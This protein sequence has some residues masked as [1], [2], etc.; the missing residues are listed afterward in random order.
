MYQPVALTTMT[1]TPIPPNTSLLL[2]AVVPTFLLGFGGIAWWLMDGGV[3]GGV[4]GILGLLGCV[5]CV[6]LL[7]LA[8][9]RFVR[10]LILHGR[11]KDG[12]DVALVD[13]VLA[14]E[15]VPS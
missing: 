15:P 5:A 14:L 12:K 9:V 6:A 13:A 2:L 3:A 8:M 11:Y 10:A 7:V 4:M 1:P